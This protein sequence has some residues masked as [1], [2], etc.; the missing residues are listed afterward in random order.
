MASP[1]FV[2]EAAAVAQVNTETPANA[3]TD[4]VYTVKLTDHLGR[5]SSVSFTVV[6]TETVAAV[7]A[8]LYALMAA[9]KAAG[10]I[11]WT[12]VTTSDETTHVEITADTAGDPFTIATAITDGANGAAPTLT[13][14]ITTACSGPKLYGIAEN[15]DT[16][17]IP[18]SSDTPILPAGSYDIYGG[19][20]TSGVILGLFTREEGHTGDIGSLLKPLQL[21]SDTGFNLDG[22]GE[23]HLALTGATA[24]VNITGAGSGS[25]DGTYGMVIETGEAAMEINIS[26]EPSESVGLAPYAGQTGTFTPINIASGT[27]K[28]GSGVTVTDIVVGSQAEVTCEASPSGDITIR[29]GGEFARNGSASTAA[30][31]FVEAGGT[32]IENAGGNVSGNVKISGSVDT[33][34]SNHTRSWANTDCHRGYS[35]NDPGKTITHTAHVT[36]NECDHTTH[37]R[38]EDYNVVYSAAS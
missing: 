11:P 1:K 2:H 30:D 19:D 33:S 6:T 3:N 17:A 10:E 13:D 16:G 25:G 28:I 14:A 38:G 34:Q 36:Y 22:A 23:V 20:Y 21:D 15:W 31:I 12:L 7:C 37:D 5:S 32:L 18:V 4:D 9:A 27:V 8:G 35:I 29:R 26:C 24:T